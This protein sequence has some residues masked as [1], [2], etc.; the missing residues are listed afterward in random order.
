MIEDSGSGILE[1]QAKT[2][3]TELPRAFTAEKEAERLSGLALADGE[4][5]EQA[6]GKGLKEIA[7]KL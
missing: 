5:A 1:Q 3:F 6:I 4:K 2:Y 7:E